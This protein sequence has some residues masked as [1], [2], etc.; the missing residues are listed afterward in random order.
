MTLSQLEKHPAASV[1]GW[2]QNAEHTRTHAPAA[3]FIGVLLFFLVHC[4]G[5]PTPCRKKTQQT[6]DDDVIGLR[7]DACLSDGDPSS[8]SDFLKSSG[9]VERETLNHVAR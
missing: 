9:L 7:I 3:N 5:K 4:A 1:N 8:W 2:E 6:D